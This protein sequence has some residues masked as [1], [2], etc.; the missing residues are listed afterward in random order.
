MN[1]TAKEV[2]NTAVSNKYDKGGNYHD[3][4]Q[5]FTELGL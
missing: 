3:R 5:K 1:P 4:H 2:Q